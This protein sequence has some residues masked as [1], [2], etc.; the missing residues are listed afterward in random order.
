MVEIRTVNG[1]GAACCSGNM[2]GINPVR[3]MVTGLNS[4][5]F[6]KYWIVI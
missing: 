6:I 3:E 5:L 2:S 1:V 4:L